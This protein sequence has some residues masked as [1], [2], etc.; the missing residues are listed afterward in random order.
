[1]TDSRKSSTKINQSIVLL[2]FLGLGLMYLSFHLEFLFLLLLISTAASSWV[3]HSPCLRSPRC[4]LGGCWPY[5]RHRR[6]PS[7]KTGPSD[8]GNRI[9][10]AQT[11][12]ACQGVA[13]YAPSLKYSCVRAL[14]E[15]CVNTFWWLHWGIDLLQPWGS[16]TKGG[17]GPGAMP[18][19]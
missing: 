1:M 15:T 2:L 19:A 8:L 18:W 7:T 3:I 14:T 6:A 12:R 11:V 13:R 9:N 16:T 4:R 10:Q 17:S 5:L